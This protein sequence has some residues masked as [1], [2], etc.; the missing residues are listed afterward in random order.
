MK[1]NKLGFTLIEIIIVLSIISIIALIASP[2]Y[3][4]YKNYANEEEASN[5]G[6]GIYLSALDYRLINNE[7]KIECLKEFIEDDLGINIISLLEK[8][9]DRGKVIEASYYS[10]KG[11]YKCS[12]DIDK[13][14]YKISKIKKGNNNE[15][16]ILYKNYSYGDI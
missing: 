10:G 6:R 11:I 13:N 9:Y 3:I 15:E 5:I 16:K 12:F 14:K 7:L 8:P 1:N 2:N 4:Q